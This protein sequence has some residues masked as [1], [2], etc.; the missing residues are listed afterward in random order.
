METDHQPLVALLKKHH[1]PGHLL[2]WTLALQEYTFTLI[3]CRGS[4]NLIA[5]GL[6]RTEFQATQF[7]LPVEDLPLES[8]KMATLQQ[9]NPH[10]QELST[11][12]QSIVTNAAH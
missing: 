3:Y 5:D 12:L 8:G 4:H 1:P 6:S 10:L 7:F 11:Q 2:R 9:L